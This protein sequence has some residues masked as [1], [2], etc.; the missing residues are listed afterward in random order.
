MP[1]LNLGFGDPI[2]N[3][4]RDAT[5]GYQLGTAIRRGPELEAQQRQQF[6][7]GQQEQQQNIA[8]RNYQLGQMDREQKTQQ[9][10][11]NLMGWMA[12]HPD[13][14]GGDPDE[15]AHLL[16]MSGVPLSVGSPQ[17]EG[18][19]RTVL[20]GKTGAVHLNDPA[21]VAAYN[22]LNNAAINRDHIGQQT[23]D[24][25]IASRQ[26]SGLGVTPQ[27]TTA[28]GQLV[29]TEDGSQHYAPPAPI[30]QDLEAQ[31]YTGLD[32]LHQWVQQNPWAQAALARYSKMA[33]QERMAEEQRI[34]KG[35]YYANQGTLP[36]PRKLEKIETTY[37]GGQKKSRAIFSDGTSSLVDPEGVSAYRPT[38]SMGTQYVM[39]DAD[40]NQEPWDGEDIPAGSHVIRVGTAKGGGKGG[41]LGDKADLAAVQ[42]DYKAQL[43]AWAVDPKRNPKPD[44]QSIKAQHTGGKSGTPATPQD[45]YVGK[46]VAG[47]MMSAGT[48]RVD[49][50]GRKVISRGNGKWQLEK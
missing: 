25:P 40:G 9:A 35:A 18:D 13:G 31:H 46:T 42:E 48:V 21:H 33:P 38:N 11:R 41:D 3:A 27:G 10:N 24:G 23:P 15:F 45:G 34:I 49:G 20:S 28:A 39:E 2:G 4:V 29:T 5:A 16:V 8:V 47:P 44:W 19:M 50:K 36:P 6:D 43:Q 32:Q 14:A 22:S 37:E 17:F 30:D 1:G 7:T 12:Q 26:V